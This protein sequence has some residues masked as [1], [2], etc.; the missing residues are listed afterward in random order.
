MAADVETNRETLAVKELIT[1][2]VTNRKL[3]V[4]SNVENVLER[5]NVLEEL[6]KKSEF[7]KLVIIRLIN[8]RGCKVELKLT[9]T[10]MVTA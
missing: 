9:V 3:C 7:N 8:D 5:F 4:K 6:I 1:D 10:I 2:I